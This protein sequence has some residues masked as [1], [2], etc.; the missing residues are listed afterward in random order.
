MTMFTCIRREDSGQS[1]NFSLNKIVSM[2]AVTL[3]HIVQSGLSLDFFTRPPFSGT[4]I[5][6]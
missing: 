5:I 1:K 2:F 6:Q 3:P 4:A